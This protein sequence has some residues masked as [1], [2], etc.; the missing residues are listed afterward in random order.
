MKTKDEWLFGW[1]KISEVIENKGREICA[2]GE[3]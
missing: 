1:R 2:R 3:K